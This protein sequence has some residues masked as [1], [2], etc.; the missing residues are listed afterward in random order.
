MVVYQIDSKVEFQ[1][2]TANIKVN[3]KKLYESNG[4]SVKELSKIASILYEAQKLQKSA[5]AGDGEIISGNDDEE[6]NDGGKI[7]IDGGGDESEETNVYAI[8]SQLANRVGATCFTAWIRAILMA[9]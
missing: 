4:R 6:G 8:L 1:L 5:S 2:T 9:L 7:K 3:P